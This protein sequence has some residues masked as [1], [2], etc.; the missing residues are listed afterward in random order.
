MW[1]HV[2][3]NYYTVAILITTSFYFFLFLFFTFTI[4]NKSQATRHLGLT[5]LGTTLLTVPYLFGHSLY[6]PW[7]VYHRYWTVFAVFIIFIHLAQFFY[8]YQNKEP[9]RWIRHILWGQYA[10]LFLALAY[11]IV[12]TRD[13][14]AV[15]HFDG[16]IWD[17][18]ADDISRHIGV[19]I[20]L[21]LLHFVVAGLI[22]FFQMKGLRG[23]RTLLILLTIL[24]ISQILP[25]LTNTLA[26]DG[27]VS[28]S[29]HQTLLAVLTV[30][31]YFA[32]VIIYIN[33]TKDKTT[34]MGKI[35]GVSVVTF[36]LAMQLVAL[37][38]FG[39]REKAYHRYQHL[40]TQKITFRE[41]MRPPHLRYIA[42]TNV[43]TGQLEYTWIHPSARKA[44]R[45]GEGENQKGIH[46]DRL[47]QDQRGAWVFENI[48]AIWP[49][50]HAAN[51]ERPAWLRQAL[52]RLDLLGEYGDGHRE[53]LKYLLLKAAGN[54]DLKGR[55]KI[56]YI[57]T[58][59]QS[60][61][62]K[63]LYHASKIRKLPAA[64]YRANLHDYAEKLAEKEVPLGYY[65]SA[66]KNFLTAHPH[67]KGKQ[68]REKALLFLRPLV[69]GDKARFRRTGDEG[70]HFTSYRALTGQSGQILEAGFDYIDYRIALH[71]VAGRFIAILL[72]FLAIIILGFPFFFRQAL[73]S[74]LEELVSGV[75]KVNKGDLEV[76]IPV[77]VED[78]IGFLTRAFNRMV[79]SIRAAKAR[80]QK[81]ADE[82]EQ[83]VEDRT[84]ELREILEEVQKLKN[85]QDGDYFLTSL[86][87][88]PLAANNVH[89]ENIAVD[90]FVRQKKK[91]AFR[92]W[93][94]EIGGDICSAHTI[95]LKGRKHTV[96]LNA[97][98]MGKSMQGAGGA[99][100]LGA[101]FESVIDRTML[102]QNYQ[103][104]YPERWLKNVFIDLQ[105]IFES[106]D[107]S[108]LISAAIG[109][110]DD[111]TGLMYYINAE[112]PWTAM[113]R[114][115]KATFIEKELTFRKLGTTGMSGQ[116]YVQTFQLRPGDILF[117]GSD[118][119][120]DLLLGYDKDNNRIINE[121]ENL[122]LEFIEKSRGDM[123]KLVELIISHGELTDDLSL[124]RVSYDPQKA[125]LNQVT[126]DRTVEQY[127]NE[128][129]PLV[130]NG[131]FGKAI[132]LL[133]KAMERETN[134]PRVFKQLVRSYVKEKDYARA[135]E[136][137]ED[138][139]LVHPQ[140]TEMIYWSSY[141]FKKVRR[142]GLAADLGERVRLRE[143]D[144]VRNLLNLSDVYMRMGNTGRCLELL[145]KALKL[146]P[147]NAQAAKLRE[148]ARQ[149]EAKTGASIS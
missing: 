69:W 96:F 103:D 37:F 75:G 114:D 79:W 140:D 148:A 17:F 67:L 95:E 45:P 9:A 63:L 144:R 65:G 138:Y 132:P 6:H 70:H 81:H 92:K 35:T 78:E 123:E 28:W 98:A 19:L 90:F 2:F 124:V 83:K 41:N 117:A 116:I 21:Y 47:L 74:P 137:V 13:R 127:L 8:Y 149:R 51:E 139:I 99:L 122:F 135:A 109:L 44:I 61:Y 119:R 141:I 85:Q 136:L 16:M 146:E 11:F 125:P 131:E 87:I 80:L 54:Q 32:A 57:E 84:R 94:E 26:R 105:R 89:S 48:L 120:D 4:P 106:F 50:G 113:L 31:G 56:R 46:S 71:N 82:L 73:L 12:A 102:A 101:V 15:Y 64:A 130:K 68:L 34:F 23:R 40:L 1:D 20:I 53:Y 10:G 111:E 72:G 77:H 147:K 86:M 133:E 88:K 121:D 145:D 49:D 42:K 143:P 24:F 27:R 97:D 112:H 66:I 5:F 39:D 30:L 100:V 60:V 134:H 3:F 76:K 93:K 110:I 38:S 18:D 58:E 55:A 115:G 104:Q 52:S 91:F 108:M 128:A 118:G 33:I 29:L 14:G 62:R 129:I 107:G 126:R 22:R 59:V 25:A 7:L 43:K 142:Y 36:L